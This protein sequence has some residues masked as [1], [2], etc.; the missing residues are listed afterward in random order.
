MLFQP[1][2]LDAVE[3]EVI[4]RINNLRKSLNYAVRDPVRW[5]GLLRRVAFAR[6]IRSSNSIEGYNVTVDDAVASYEREEPLDPRTEAWLAVSGYREAMT[7]VVQ[8]AEDPH[9]RYSVDLLRSLQYMMLSFD[10]LK[11]PG[12]WRPGP[13]SV[14][15]EEK[16]E[17][18]YEGP[19]ALEVPRLMH[20]LVDDLNRNDGGLTNLVDASL[21][22]LN[23]A[24]I[25]PF[26]DGNGRM[27]R[28]LQTLTLARSG[29]LATPFSSIEEYLGH[30]TREY[31][32]I[33]AEVG[34][35]AWNPQNDTR[36]WV[37]FCLTAHFR[38]AN[39][40]LRRLREMKRLWDALESHIDALHLPERMLFALADAAIGLRVRNATYRKAA[41]ISN[42]LASHDLVKLN[43]L[44][45]LDAHGERKGRYYR[46]S[47]TLE[48]IRKLTREPKTA[49]DPFEEQEIQ[50]PLLPGME[51]Y[52]RS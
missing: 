25:H 21:A 3:L 46:S 28:C 30:N 18:V 32:D 22:H 44:K 10:L 51:S 27:A 2:V 36:P 6:A 31:Y 26:S 35:G 49:Q 19:D 33:L 1:P 52:A 29:V 47:E 20:E 43:R 9:F 16:S 7:Y 45:L 17:V 14:I 5:Q 34:G 24:M 50:A 42:T 48:S 23:L 8:L 38:Q 13:I 37:R 40:L 15:D 12:R 41:E 4:E 39:T 11:N